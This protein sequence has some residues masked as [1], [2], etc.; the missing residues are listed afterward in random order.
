MNIIN[1]IRSFYETN[2][3]LCMKIIAAIVIIIAII[4][5]ASASKGS[6][7][8][9]SFA[10][11]NNSGRAVQD[12]SWIYFS[13]VEDN[14]STGIYKVKQNSKKATEVIKGDLYYLNLAD[15]YIYCLEKDDDDG[16][17]NLVKIKKN[18]NNKCS[19]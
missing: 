5:V 2:R 19:R 10:N 12:G 14:A 16:Q 18:G 9:N 15:N 11:S 4:V 17:N 13:K 1:V 6:K 3:S 8:G 7:Y